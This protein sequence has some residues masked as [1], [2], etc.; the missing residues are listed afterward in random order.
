MHGRNRKEGVLLLHQ[1]DQ[2]IPI[3]VQ[4]PFLFH[5]NDVSC[6]LCLSAHLG[7]GGGGL[8]AGLIFSFF[9]FFLF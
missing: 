4:P 3:T 5:M 6:C 8:L 9:Y 7:R 2:S 1:G